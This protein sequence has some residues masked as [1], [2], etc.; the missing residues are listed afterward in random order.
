MPKN[1]KGIGYLGKPGSFS[2]IASSRY[3]A[4]LERIPVDSFKEIIKRV[5]DGELHYGILPI[6][7]SVSGSVVTNYDLLLHAHVT[8]CG[9]IYLRVSQNLLVKKG[10]SR[11]DITI[12]Y[13]H[14]EAFKQ[15]TVFLEK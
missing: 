5:E 15:C 1:K 3:N 9:E 2:F 6:E 8:I 10:T 12:V 14:P 11:N 7:N 4:E 13:S